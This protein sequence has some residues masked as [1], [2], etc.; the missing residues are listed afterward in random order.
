[1]QNGELISNQLTTG[2]KEIEWFPHGVVLNDLHA[3]VVLTGLFT[4]LCSLI[5]S[6]GGGYLTEISLYA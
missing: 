3:G 5:F 1:M 6:P 4:L 2:D